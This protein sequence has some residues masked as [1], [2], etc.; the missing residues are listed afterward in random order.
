MREVRS[1]SGNALIDNMNSREPRAAPGGDAGARTVALS[2]CRAGP[3]RSVELSTRRGADAMAALEG[4]AGIGH[5]TSVSIF[6][7]LLTSSNA[8]MRRFAVEGLARAGHRDALADAPADGAD[9]SVPTVC[10]SRST[11]R[12]SSSARLQAASS[13]S[14]LRWATHRSVRSRWRYLLDLSTSSGSGAGGVAE[15]SKR[16]DV[17]APC[18]RRPWFLTESGRRSR[19]RGGDKRFRSRCCRRRPAGD[20]ADQAVMPL[21]RAFYA[22]P[23]LVVARDL[24]GKVL[25]HRTRAGLTSGIIVEV[26]AYIGESDPACHAAPGPTKRN[27]PMYGPPGHA[28]VYLNYGVHRLVNVVTEPEQSP[29][30]VLIR[31]LEPLDG[32]PLMRRRRMRSRTVRREKRVADPRSRALPGPGQPDARDG[33]YAEGHRRGSARRDSSISKIAGI[34]S[35]RSRGARGS[36]SRS[37]RNAAGGAIGKDTDRCLGSAC[38]L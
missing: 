29:A 16:P 34:A 36:A 2:E 21:P 8:E 15:G 3:V 35:T 32:I 12:T 22:R 23:T 4:L 5:A 18:R 10:C 14:W 31:A 30:A 38:S 20:R 26:E 17:A 7:R 13:S 25:V 6:K 33:D 28:Y 19:A 24:L 1:Q 9:A 27:A 37:G 11:T